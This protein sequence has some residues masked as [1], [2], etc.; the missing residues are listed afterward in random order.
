MFEW[1]VVRSEHRGIVGAALARA[2][3]GEATLA[4]LTFRAARV[5]FIVPATATARRPARWPDVVADWV[6]INEERLF[7][8]DLVSVLGEELSGLGAEVL[9][10]FSE[11]DLRKATT[12]WYRKGALAELEYVGSSQVAWTPEAGLGRPFDGA[13]RSIGAQVGRR[14]AELVGDERTVNLMD[15]LEGQ[16]LAVG[17][18]ILE[19]AF[20]RM[21]GEAPPKMDELRGSVATAAVERVSLA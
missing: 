13:R 15:R 1:V 9:A 18:A 10:T 3:R 6:D 7:P 2:W 14:V 4:E 5:T 16:R 17:E 11:L 12:G 8:S 21:F 19:S 20:S